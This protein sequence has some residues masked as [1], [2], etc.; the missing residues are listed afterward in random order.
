VSSANRR[1]VEFIPTAISL[2]WKRNRE[3]LNTDPYGTP[4]STLIYSDISPSSATACDL[5]A[6]KF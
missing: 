6:R 4:D 3:W 1:T 5:L 2:M